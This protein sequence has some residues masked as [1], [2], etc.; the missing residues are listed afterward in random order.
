[1][2]FH[3]LHSARGARVEPG[4]LVPGTVCAR[5]MSLERMRCMR[6]FAAALR[7]EEGAEPGGGDDVTEATRGTDP[8]VLDAAGGAYPVA[9]DAAD[10]DGTKTDMNCDDSDDEEAAGSIF[11]RRWAGPCDS[12]RSCARCHFRALAEMP[13]AVVVSAVVGIEVQLRGSSVRQIR[14]WIS[15]PVDLEYRTSVPEIDCA[16]NLTRRRLC[17]PNEVRTAQRFVDRSSASCFSSWSE[18]FV[19][20][21]FPVLVLGPCRGSESHRRAPGAPDEKQR[22][23]RANMHG[24]FSPGSEE[25]V[26]AHLPPT[27]SEKAHRLS[28]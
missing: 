14:K 3:L 15:L 17:V 13:R 20:D 26:T 2:L 28:R 7:P 24:C 4:R 11:E 19:S 10:V 21:D 23:M 18:T 5:G 16:G 12:N 1:M 9:E 27:T 6:L 22:G 8:V 25:L